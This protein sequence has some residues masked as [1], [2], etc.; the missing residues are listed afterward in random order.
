M[1]WY[2]AVFDLILVLVN[3]S[4]FFDPCEWSDRT[5]VEDEYLYN[6]VV[7]PKELI[8]IG[9]LFEGLF[10]LYR[11][12]TNTTISIWHLRPYMLYLE[13]YDS[14]FVLQVNYY[15]ISRKQVEIALMDFTF[16]MEKIVFQQMIGWKPVKDWRIELPTI[17]Y[18]EDSDLFNLYYRPETSTYRTLQTLYQ[19]GLTYSLNISESVRAHYDHIIPG[20]GIVPLNEN[21]YMWVKKCFDINAFYSQMIYQRN[22]TLFHVENCE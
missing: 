13:E 21:F 19:I 6:I 15:G 11:K 17:Y 10:D 5:F 18:Q 2:S 4:Q 8:H 1:H 14:E 9:L 22:Q 20:R 7:F 16:Q 3:T 12:E